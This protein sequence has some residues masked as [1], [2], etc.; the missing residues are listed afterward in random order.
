M[1]H[2]LLELTGVGR[3][4][5]GRSGSIVVLRD[6]NLTIH[7]GEFVAIMGPSGSGKSTLMNILG[8]LDRPSTGSYRVS[9]QDT[10]RLDPDALARLRRQTFGFIFQR[11][12]LLADL[13]AVENAAIPAV[14]AGVPQGERTS[15]SIRLL[16]QLGLRDRLHHRPSELSG[17][18]QQRVSIARALM[19]GATTILADEPT[20]ALD[21]QSGEEVLRTLREL[22]DAG[23]TIILITHDAQ[24]ARHARR[25]IKLHDGR[26]VSDQTSPAWAASR[27]VGAV[28]RPSAN[29]R[30]PS[31][32]VVFN[33][34]LR[35]ALRSLMHNRLRTALTMLGIVIGVASVVAMLAIGSG[36][37]EDVLQR[38]QAMGTDLLDVK[39]GLAAVRGS[40]KGV[41]TLTPEDLP[42]LTSLPGVV[43]AVPETEAT[44]VLRYGNKDLEVPAVG[45]NDEF[46]AVRNWPLQRG[47]FFTAADV[48]R[49]G[50]VVVLGDSVAQELFPDGEN[51]IGKYVILGNAP[52]QVSGVMAVKGVSSRGYDQDYQV[53]VPYT[54]ATSLLFG[55]R[56]FSDVN[57]KVRNADLMKQV[58]HAIHAVLIKSHGTEDFNIR[59][60]ADLIDT[61]NQAQDTFTNLL[62]AVAVISLIVGGIGVMNIMLVSVVE[63]TREIG[64][65]MAV[66]ARGSDV[67]LQFLTEA[68][69]VC[70]IGGALGV[71]VGIAGALAASRSLGWVTIFS[72]TPAVLALGCA[73]ATGLA[74]GYLPARKAARLDPVQALAWE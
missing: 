21:S 37:K 8:C 20:G 10:A 48:K 63:R 58:E 41:V 42:L 45:T 68:A 2:A 35:M 39:R 61:A 72:P 9:G 22:N 65:R 13:N 36:A 73:C 4:F 46:P 44:V 49:Y 6:I 52:Y 34:A 12:N 30:S 55:Y 28:S 16:E 50:L 38:I 51:P 3:E 54:T 24:V 25:L 33:E 19:N 56:Y 66:G 47:V 64:V 62:A 57:V 11:Y 67:L 1:S 31:A 17:G 70:A 53:W 18:Q 32:G 14:Y 43:A 69:V 15:R 7:P 23:R 60:M 59:N 40:S 71:V 26:M 27:P 29:G 74:F 5:Y